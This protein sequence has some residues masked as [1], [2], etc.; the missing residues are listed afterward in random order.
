MYIL[1]AMC[2]TLLTL[3][4]GQKACSHIYDT[5]V[6]MQIKLPLEYNA[7]E[8]TAESF[9]DNSHPYYHSVWIIYFLHRRRKCYGFVLFCRDELLVCTELKIWAH[10]DRKELVDLSRSPFTPK[11]KPSLGVVTSLQPLQTHLKPYILIVK[12][13]NQHGQAIGV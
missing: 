8:I 9:P 6:S 1:T 2:A 5:M 11:H 7:W 13:T 3:K 10:R 4:T 12:A